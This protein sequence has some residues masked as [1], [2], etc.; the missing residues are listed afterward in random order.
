MDQVYA[1]QKTASHARLN[2]AIGQVTMGV[3]T[4]LLVALVAA[5]ALYRQQPP[6]A[7]PA[8]APP[9]EFASGR[10]LNTLKDIAQ[11]PHQVGSPEHS[12]VRD[13]LVRQL[14][15]A[16]LAPEVQETTAVN[17]T[18]PGPVIAGTVSNVMGRLKGTANTRALML[19]AHYD[20]MPTSRGASDDGSGV[21]T[22]LE[23]L[24]ALKAG[25][26]LK[27]D[28]IFLFTDGEEAGLLGAHAF[29]AE[30]PWAKDV[31]L[32]LNFE[33]RGTSGPAYM[34]E[35]SDRNGWLVSEF[36]KAA[37]SPAA[38]S[39]AYEIYR[40]LPNDTDLTV[41]KGAGI[42]GLN[43]AYINDLPYYHTLLDSVENLDER[44]LQHQGS[45]ALS[46][47]R[48]FGDSDLR[49]TRAPNA[50][51]FRLLGSPLIHYSTS[52]VLPLAVLAVLAFAGLVIFGLRR[53]RL[54]LKGIALGIV[55][56]LLSLL[57]APVIGT[58]L[59][60]LVSRVRP[61]SSGVPL[62]GA[63]H[64][65]LYLA[66]F[67]ALTIAVVS[68]LYV[69]FRKGA[70]VPNLL[71]G[72]LFAWLA[73]LVSSSLV[74]P[75]A[76]YLFFWPLLFGLV[77]LGFMVGAKSEQPG[78]LKEFLLLALC[79]VPAVALLAPTVYEVAVALTLNSVAPVIVLVVL[80]L[81]LLIPHLKVM[82]TPYRWALPVAA[83]VAGLGII[84]ATTLS[85]RASASE[86]KLDTIFYGLNAD[87]G[88]AVW[89]SL[90]ERPDGWTSQFFGP[91]TR[92][93]PL[94]DL[95]TPASPRAY[96][97]SPA[98]AVQLT[99]PQISL[100]G[101]EV[102][103]GDGVRTLRL[104]VSSPRRAGVVA[105]YIDSPEAGVLESSVNGKPLRNAARPGA[106]QPQPGWSMLYYA[107]PT[108]GIDLTAKVK[109]TQP[110][111]VRVVDQS[112]GLPEIPGR[113]FSSRPA[114]IIPAP[115]RFL[116]D[117]TL[118]SKSFT[119]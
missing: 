59:W 48:H 1:D 19:V 108:D 11:S 113:D 36:A 103:A 12:A 64:S 80:L 88:K 3:L 100:I 74:V 23:T 13:Y 9:T 43:F 75:G 46:L 87:T 107:F 54:T 89:A 15:D 14:T 90:D 71:A 83:A 68:A 91:G 17:A 115:A 94:P 102:N 10:A 99:P 4:F 7:V 106:A 96:L 42:P 32:V 6:S 85:A 40:L 56:F 67:V 8:G 5:Y 84:L 66:G 79:A 105:L 118:V 28:L 98:P 117:T 50:V 92:S 63:Y 20:S 25:P 34:F 72:A 62:S 29:V 95:F 104:H 69:L 33:A 26:P 109:T 78:P 31:G 86:P 70:S 35:T 51:Y 77:T 61:A 101:D 114:D 53:G 38:H 81:G 82:A 60:G 119:F 55:F 16:G 76:S 112:H 39:L 52:W 22:L 30:H 65:D 116:N 49:E 57:A 45:Y 18:R 2:L 97:N 24:R 58:L 111:K 21:A 37:P 110:V 73:L 44:S 41:F 47:A 93:G 27:N